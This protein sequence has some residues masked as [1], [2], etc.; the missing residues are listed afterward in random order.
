MRTPRE[1]EGKREMG[2]GDTEDRPYEEVQYG[3][4]VS[5]YNI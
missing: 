5:E 1:R 4:E 2:G 3:E